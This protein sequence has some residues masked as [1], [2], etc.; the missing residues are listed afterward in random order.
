MF[1]KFVVTGS[2]GN[3]S[4]PLTKEL[5]QKGHM[6]TVISSKPEKQKDIE[7]LGAI[8]AIGTLEDVDFLVSTFT[9]ADAVYCM[10]PPNNYFDLSLDLLT[11][12][13]VVA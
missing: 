1:M 4:K 13:G 3:I 8:A 5:V 2:L 7:A 12:Y 9:G 6:V 10:V 11:Y